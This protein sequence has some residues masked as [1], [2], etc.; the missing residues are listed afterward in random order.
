MALAGDRAGAENRL[1]GARL[2]DA[3]RGEAWFATGL[4]RLARDDAEGARSAFVSAARA[5][6]PPGGL[7]TRKRDALR[8]GASRYEAFIAF[9]DDFADDFCRF[10]VPRA[11]APSE[12][13][14]Y[15]HAM[16]RACRTLGPDEA[17]ALLEADRA[18][19]GETAWGCVNLGHRRW[20]AGERDAA[21]AHYRRAREIA[22]R[23]GLKPYHFNCGTLVWLPRGEAAALL[24]A[25]PPATGLSHGFAPGPAELAFVVGCDPNYFLFFPKLLLSAVAAHRR[26]GSAVPV[27]VHC[28]LSDP[29]E[30]Q[31]AFL[32]EA[33]AL[34][35]RLSPLVSLGW[36]TGP[37]A[38]R[39]PD[40]YTGLRFLALP[41]VIAHH[42]C[43]AVALDVDCALL[44][45]FFAAAPR[46]LDQDFA[47]R[48]YAFDESFRQVS[49]EPWSIGAHPTH[50]GAGPAGRRFAA[51]LRAYLHAAYDPALVT[52][53]TID[54]CAIA[55]GYD[56]IV[57]PD[58]SLRVLNLAREAPGYRLP[59]EDGGKAAFLHAGGAVTM[60][61]FAERLAAALA[62][63][64]S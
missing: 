30:L 19:N 35:A 32:R 20:I 52:N 56:L 21:D 28:C 2:Q 41:D 4:L 31:A 59:E 38:H 51:F 10:A 39:H 49:G 40:W 62:G 11:V 55:Q 47:L 33:A 27:V 46:L 53:W 34:L 13:Q 48:M 45:E 42:G 58:R 3:D 6:F 8:A 18:L 12:R 5:R 43:A 64:S 50:V 29:T 1:G 57:R 7:R 26:S 63:A 22:A 15:F 23:D 54:Q 9:Y 14:G 61:N 36:S 24:D 16:D 25:E 44:P 37:A 17:E 60:A